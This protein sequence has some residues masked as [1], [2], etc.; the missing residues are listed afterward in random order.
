LPYQQSGLLFD[1]DLLGNCVEKGMNS[2]LINKPEARY[3]GHLLGCDEARH[4]AGVA[5]FTVS[6]YVIN[7]DGYIGYMNRISA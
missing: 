3:R 7:A 2:F 1:G 4:D 6:G 5:F